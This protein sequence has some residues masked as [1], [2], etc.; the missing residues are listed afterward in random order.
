MALKLFW[1]VKGKAY[2]ETLYI[3]K[4]VSPRQAK[5]IVER[6]RKV[7]KPLGYEE[8]EDSLGQ[9]EH[10]THLL[11]DKKHGILLEM[12]IGE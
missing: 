1:I 5:E 11:D 6:H 12:F 9:V 3:V 8:D 10:E 2:K 4:A 7:N